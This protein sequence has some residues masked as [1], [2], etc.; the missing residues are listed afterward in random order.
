MP[1]RRV[2]MLT[3]LMAMW[4]FSGEA[5][6]SQPGLAFQQ[7]SIDESPAFRDAAAQAVAWEQPEPSPNSNH[8]PVTI[9]AINDF[10]GRLLAERRSDARPMGGA[11]VLAA[12]LNA[13]AA[14]EPST[15]STFIVHAGDLVGASPPESALLQ[16]EPSIAF[17]NLLGNQHCRPT[18]RLNP[19][20][21]LVGTPGN[22]EFDE[23]QDELLRLVNGGSHPS[24]PFLADPYE[25]AAF[26]YVSANV[27]E[28][29]TGRP[30]FPPFVIKHAN[31]VRA[32]F[33]GAVLK[34]TPSIVLPDG[35]AG[36]A[37]LDEAESINR[38]V[39]QLRE[40]HG[41]RTFIV[42]LHQGGRQA[43]YE[44]RTQP[45]SQVRGPEIADI[46]SRLDDDVDVVVSGHAHAFT[47]AMMTNR[48]GRPILLTQAFSYGTAYSEIHLLID[49]ATGDVASKSSAIVT[50]YG[51]AGPG[52]APEPTVARLVALAEAKIAPLVRR[53]MAESAVPIVR[54]ENEAGESPLGRLIADAQR[55]AMQTDFAF[56]NPGG[57]RGDL[58]G[59]PL[60]YREVFTVQP[61]G[62]KL[63]R[64]SL[65]GQQI[66]DLLNQQWTR[67]QPRMLKVSGLSYTWDPGRQPGDRVLD[68]RRQGVPLD[69][70]ARYSVTVNDYLAAGGDNFSV[71]AQ[72]RSREAGPSD[73]EALIAYLE[74]LP[75]PVRVP[76]ERRITIT[77]VE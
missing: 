31:G 35:V 47:N 12:Y 20:C 40:Q 44:G 2:V 58:P 38:Y 9:L 21:N 61:F 26:P 19:D 73:L 41:I 56:V 48:H 72:S 13:A 50:T 11:A 54:A 33:I 65:T 23:G 63:I 28:R 49:R 77:Q 59:G 17:F 15:H 29:V 1:D 43:P 53:M 52:L 64:L 76:P 18:D 22:H 60:T 25:G 34:E 51:D 74:S 68:V 8:I 67:P 27:T 39:R 7:E 24:G 6:A 10:H 62:N 46:L 3:C 30:I 4:G 14:R 71:F 70:A 66:Y 55:A 16:D 32:A 45:A 36:L 75:Q 57:I 37:F 69:R 42:L 5:P